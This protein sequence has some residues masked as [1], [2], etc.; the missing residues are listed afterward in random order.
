MQSHPLGESRHG[1]RGHALVNS[2]SDVRLHLV[3]DLD[4]ALDLMSWLG[5]RRV[6]DIAVDT[7]TEGLDTKKDRVRLVQIGDEMHGW[8][9]PW[10][11]WGGVFL[12][13]MKK[14]DGR[15][16]MHNAKFDVAM[17]RNWC[18]Y[19]VPQDRCHDTRLMAHVIEPTY[20]TALKRL[21]ARHID[22][23]AGGLQDQLG[24]AF[25]SGWTWATVPID[26]QPYWSYAALDCV[27]TARLDT[28]LMQKVK[29]AGA[30]RAYE[31][32]LAAAWV[33]MG[34]EQNGIAVDRPYAQAAFDQFHGY[35]QTLS[36]WCKANYDVRPSQ[37]ASV[38]EA[39]I[40]DGVP[41]D[42]ATASGALKLDKKI[43][44]PIDHPLAQTVLTYRQYSKVT[45]TYL[46]A[47]L[48]LT[49]DEDPRLVPSINTVGKLDDPVRTGRMSM[50]E[51]NLQN[52]PRKTEGRPESLAVRN[53]IVSGEESTLLMIDFSQIELR[54]LA[55]LSGDTA[56][57]EAFTGDED[58]FTRLARE[59]Y[60]VPDMLR[61][62][63]RRSS[64]KNAMYSRVYG[65]GATKFAAT[66]GI[67]IE[68]GQEIYDLIAS[69]YPGT[70]T[71]PR[72]IQSTATQ[73]LRDEGR[74]YVKSPLTGRIL[75]VDDD[76]IYVATNYVIQGMA[77][78]IFKYKLC[79]LANAGL[80][81][82]MCLPVHDEVVF[83]VPSDQL[84]EVARIALT[85][86]NDDTMLSV[87]IEAEA[88][89]G[90]RWGQKSDYTP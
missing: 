46:K 31:L 78:E 13:A 86:M 82:F 59:L 80:Q 24:S 12:E 5:E 18:S 64:T 88:S 68:E 66:A 27:L 9:I 39:L 45:S 2:L 37:N 65:A 53:C 3:D 6:G 40:R 25:D 44:G 83:D 55:H 70:V 85:V 38:A 22:P 7:E 29:D 71:M 49:S 56:L 69:R 61:S 33:C 48:N 74:A 36:D 4:T 15:L 51:P 23:T 67:S 52:L 41:L 79:E 72:S 89:V 1:I 17:L 20:S 84:Q 10:E 54:V 76:K 47:F 58:F 30:V 28:I 32:E 81:E 87:P 75:P 60:R 8:A 35:A 50:S 16:L 21:A 73:R 34:M 26:F 62:D 19:Q 42:A 57:Q 43:L 77:A 11:K 14:Y 90:A 63:D